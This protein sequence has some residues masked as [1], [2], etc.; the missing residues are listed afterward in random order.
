[1]EYQA[2]KR[3]GIMSHLSLSVFDL[4][5]IGIGPSSSHT[6]GPMVAARTFTLALKSSP[7][8]N[9]TS[10]Q[11]DLYG[12]L[13]L[14]GEGHGTLKAVIMGLEGDGPE[15]VNVATMAQRLER[16][17]HQK[18]LNL[19]HQTPIVFDPETNIILHKEKALPEHP[20]GMTFTAKCK[21]NK[22]FSI[23]YFSTGGGFIVSQEAFNHS[24]SSS[25]LREPYPFNTATELF[26]FC[27]RAQISPAQLMWENEKTWLS[28]HE[29]ASK[30]DA[31]IDCMQNCIDYGLR[32]HGE[33]PGGL[34]VKRR[35]P[36]MFNKL[37][38]QG[39]PNP[40]HPDIMNWLN[41]YAMAVNEENAAGHRIVTAPTN[42][43]AGIIPATMRYLVDFYPETDQSTLRNFL[44]TAGAIAILYKKQ[45]SISGAEMGCQGEVGVA[46]SMA[47]GALAA[48]MGGS[49]DQIE[50]AAEIGMEHNLGLTCD[51][52]AGLV[53]IPCIERNAIASV[54]AVN[55]AQLALF[56]SCKNKISLDGVIA[57]M[58]ATGYD[59]QSIYKET[60]LGGLAVH[61]GLD[62]VSLPVNIPEC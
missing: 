8:K 31:I 58:K 19:F 2:V 24:P 49:L 21:K 20:N 55:A 37:L 18:R 50:N 25:T 32:T 59:M 9:I 40:Q 43:A 7:L 5:S 16:I 42:G 34:H 45:A 4:F 28:E 54:K 33:L 26:T 61:G 30:L 13:A 12:S 44:L 35:A 39:K 36:D 22:C 23:T 46:C 56:E 57:T 15:T 10:V 48:V 60:S 53:Q 27:K 38:Q 11:V 62:T 29:I 3:Q 6:V 51:P 52:I 41:A 17:Y 14:T 1:M 47:A